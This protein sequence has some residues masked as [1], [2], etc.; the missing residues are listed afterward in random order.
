MCPFASP[1]PRGRQKET[2]NKP[3]STFWA[4]KRAHRLVS[5]LGPAPG[6]TRILTATE[7]P[8]AV[9]DFS[10]DVRSPKVVAVG[11]STENPPIAHDFSADLRSP[12][13]LIATAIAAPGNGPLK[14]STDCKAIRVLV[15]F[16]L[17]GL[18]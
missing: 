3:L 5:G 14:V 1:G 15:W 16:F 18:L 6:H 10:S 7:I 12:K 2:Q 11:A 8:L 13:I 9:Y 4:P 17:P